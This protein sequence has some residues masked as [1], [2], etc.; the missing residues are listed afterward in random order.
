MSIFN[1]QQSITCNGK[2][3]DFKVPK[4][5]GIV[6]LTPDSFYEKSR[7]NQESQVLD[8]VAQMVVQGADMIDVGAMSSRPGANLITENEEWERL[9]PALN[10]IRSEFPELLVSIDTF[11]SSIA[12]KCISEFQVDLINDIS[13]GEFDPEIFD[14]V[15]SHHTPYV[16]MHMQGTPEDMQLNPS[17]KHLIQE[18]LTYFS[19]KIDKLLKSGVKDVIIDPGFGFGKT[20]DHNYELMGRLN[21]FDMLE[22]PVLVGVSRKSMIYKHLEINADSALNG[23]TALN[24][25]ALTKGAKIIRVHDVAEAAETVKLF[26]KVENAAN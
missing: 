21:E 16:L 13:G 15:G 25:L 20:L 18:L 19:F 2:L 11:R 26:V 10:I 14:V 12:D 3:I 4:V 7:V 17:Y 6:N 1:I 24:M 5:M 8:R 9:K 23:T 22:K